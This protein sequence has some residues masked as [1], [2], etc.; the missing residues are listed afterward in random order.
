M[1]FSYCYLPSEHLLSWSKFVW[2]KR[3]YE[4]CVLSTVKKYVYILKTTLWTVLQPLKQ[5]WNQLQL[6]CMNSARMLTKIAK[7]EGRN[8]AYMVSKFVHFRPFCR[9]CSENFVKNWSYQMRQMIFHRFV[10]V[11]IKHITF[12]Y[13][14]QICPW[15]STW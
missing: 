13:F 7:G 10:S 3:L 15:T 5:C 14:G 8:L 12:L 9:W 11:M 1:K 4:I 2:K 6:L